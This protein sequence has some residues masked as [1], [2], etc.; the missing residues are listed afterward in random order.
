[1]NS[2]GFRITNNSWGGGGYSSAM[3]T[4]ISN[5]NNAGYV[6]VAAAGNSASNNDT[7]ANYPSNYNY[8]NV[9]AVAATTRTD[10]LASFSSYGATTVDLGAPGAS[11][12]ST[13]RNGGY[14]TFD[15][16]SMAT[17]HVAGALALVW[18]KDLTQTSTQVVGKIL[19]NV[20]AIPSLSG[21]TITGGRLNVQKA[22]AAVVP[23][24]PQA[25][26]VLSAVPNG[27]TSFS[28]VRITFNLAVDLTTFSLAD[29][30]LTGP[31][32]AVTPTSLT[33]V[34][35]SNNTQFDVGFANQTTPGT[36]TISVGPSITSSSGGLMD[37]NGN[38]V[39]DAG[40]AYSGSFTVSASTGVFTFS[41]TSPTPIQDLTTT[42]STI[43]IT[44]AVQIQDINVQVNITHTYDSDL[45]LYL[46]GPDGT[47]VSL[48]RYRGTS[49]DN[50]NNTILDDEAGTSVSRGKAPFSGS[51]RPEALLS[52]YDG[53][54]TTG[55]WTLFVYDRSSLDTGTLNS[56]SLTVTGTPT[57]GSL[58]NL[59]L[60]SVGSL[61][62]LMGSPFTGSKF[63]R[64]S[65]NLS[66]LAASLP[67]RTGTTPS[68]SALETVAARRE[69]LVNQMARELVQMRQSFASRLASLGRNAATN[70]AAEMADR[71]FSRF[72]STFGL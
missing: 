38:G 42:V 18:G 30:S 57:V 10:G 7:T 65:S 60:P 27:T 29:V 68:A 64:V 43:T 8:A 23:P 32:G 41:N 54:V 45:H 56:W 72:E 55:T 1:A 53:K 28:S 16:T 61:P 13:V 58:G 62:T 47:E 9:V 63:Q 17:P 69:N 33:A 22:L 2:K 67:F 15:G 26:K 35:G 11:I 66:S 14:S 5:A 40:D 44:Q 21:K 24:A 20:D 39:G 46:R 34:S 31:G 50:F 3:A 49:G 12:L 25:L 52:A 6:F 37:Q 36:Y 19:N 71:L 48:V 70:Q 51:Y 4:A 59:R